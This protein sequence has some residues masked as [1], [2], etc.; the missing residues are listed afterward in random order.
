MKASYAKIMDDE[1]IQALCNQVKDLVIEKLVKDDVIVCK[2]DYSVETDYLVI[3][4]KKGFWGAHWDH[5]WGLEDS[6]SRQLR[7]IRVQ[8]SN[9]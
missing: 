5:F 2:E 6:K 3:L 9:K 4:A 1:D 8:H 7:V